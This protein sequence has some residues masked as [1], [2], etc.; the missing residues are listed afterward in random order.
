[1]TFSEALES[2]KNNRVV[3]LP[4]GST[5]CLCTSSDVIDITVPE[6]RQLSDV[7]AMQP[8]PLIFKSDPVHKIVQFGW[9]PTIKDLLRE[10][11]EVQALE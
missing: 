5:Y 3:C 4:D 8:E 1:M 2:L 6:I 9:L 10:D 11:W 7:L